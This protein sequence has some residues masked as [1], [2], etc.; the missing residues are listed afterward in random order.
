[1]NEIHQMN[2][3]ASKLP[4][5]NHKNYRN[6][7]NN[8][9]N[10][11]QN[12]SQNNLNNKANIKQSTKL[13]KLAKL[14]SSTE[15]E[16]FAHKHT[17]NSQIPVSLGHRRNPH[18]VTDLSTMSENS[19]KILRWHLWWNKQPTD[20]RIPLYGKQNKDIGS[21]IDS[22]KNVT[23]RPGGGNVSVIDEK[24]E[25]RYESKIDAIN[26]DYRPRGCV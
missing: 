3:P 15:S 18:N 24:L 21:K 6:S 5:L 4:E 8:S 26:K 23:H 12:N 9:A 17:R 7:S 20:L 11:S 13:P 2:D 16:Q 22:L 10:S 25:W 19:K 14:N 1:M